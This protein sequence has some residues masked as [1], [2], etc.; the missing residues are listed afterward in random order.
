MGQ[1]K[2]LVLL[3]F[4][5]FTIMAFFAFVY[6][7]EKLEKSKNEKSQEAGFDLRDAKPITPPTTLEATQ[8][9]EEGAEQ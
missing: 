9:S 1:K 3:V 8:S 2:I 4:I 5:L 6:I 7:F